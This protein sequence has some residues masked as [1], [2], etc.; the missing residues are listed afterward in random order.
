[1]LRTLTLAQYIH[2]V[3]SKEVSPR[4]VLSDITK[5]IAKENTKLNAYLALNEKAGDDIDHAVTKPLMGA[6]LAIKD[7]FLTKGIVTTASSNVLDG[8]VPQFESTAT[9]KILDA[10]GTIIGKT[11]MDAFAHGSST[12]TSDYGATKNPRNP[13][14]LPGGSSGGSAAA[15][16]ADMCI[17]AL[18]SETAGSI[19]QPSAWCGTVGLKPTYGRVSRYGAV[20]MAS[21]TDSPGPIGKTVEDTAI[22]LN[23]LAGHDDN[24]GTTSPQK[25][26]DFTRALGRS[27]K[28]MKIGVIYLDQPGLKDVAP[29]FEKELKV[30]EDL[31]AHVEEAQ[32]M[33]PRKS[34]SVYT[35]IQ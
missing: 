21:S 14:H 16:A 23:Y 4:E 27:I 15:V 32:A 2:K 34:I 28:N 25:A 9:N 19:R 30:F 7:N 10:G 17:I 29:L 33:D 3:K 5:T 6:P 35:V 31:G 26:P 8:F 1:M 24:D 11:N 20:A 22:L 12:E 18:G 13:D